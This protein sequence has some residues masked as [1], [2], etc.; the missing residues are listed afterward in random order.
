MKIYEIGTGYTPIPAQIG[1]ATE[2]VVE[3]LTR[4]FLKSG[5]SVSIVDIQAQNRRES[6]LPIL[7]VPVPKLFTGTDE[8][9]GLSHKLKRVVYSVSLAGVLKKLLAGNET[10]ERVV[11]H[12]HNQ[13]NLFFFLKLVPPSLRK[14]CLTVYT[15]H[16]YIWSGAWD[17][18]CG[19]VKK[20]YF[21]EIECMKRADLVFVLNEKTRKTVMEC[22]GIDGAKVALIENGVNTE[23]YRPLETAQNDAARAE[24]GLS[25]KRV[26]LQVGSVCERKNQLEAVR[27]LEPLLKEYDDLVYLYA[28]GIVSERYQREIQEYAKAI[29]CRDSVIYL[30]EIPPGERLNRLYSMAEAM[31]FPSQSEGFSLVILEALSAGI[32]VII[33][34]D[35]P[36]RLG[37]GCLRYESPAAFQALV[38]TEIL[39]ENRLRPTGAALHSTIQETNGWDKIAGDYWSRIAAALRESEMETV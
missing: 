34:Q 38:R 22:I 16:S 30:G 11:L 37:D 27:L 23:I 33:R 39:T 3:E 28:G 18:V 24:L 1:A 6:D 32:P 26:L 25:G 2:I 8:K 17:E 4:A 15:N 7:E 9:L 29:G 19:T 10:G 13:Y 14:K 12:F 21:Q 35:L 31:I 20:R 5:I 36:C